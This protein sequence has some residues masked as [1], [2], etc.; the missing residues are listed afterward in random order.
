MSR[1]DDVIS[2]EI[3]ILITFVISGVSEEDTTCGLEGQFVCILCGEVGIAN[4]AKHA[5]VLM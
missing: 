2:G 5:Q 4:V 1:D 3:E